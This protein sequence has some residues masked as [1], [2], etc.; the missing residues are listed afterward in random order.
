MLCELWLHSPPFFQWRG[1]EGEANWPF[2]GGTE[3]TQL[4]IDFSGQVVLVTG[5]SRGIGA[6]TANEFARHGAQVVVNYRADREGAESVAAEIT[7]SGGR[8]VLMQADVG[9]EPDIRRMMQH[10]AAELGPLRVVV[11]N[12]TGT[13]RDHFLDVTLDQLDVMWATNVR[14]PFLISQLAARQMI[15]AGKGGSILHVS[16]IL[17]QLTIENR[18]I[19]AMTKSALEGLTRSMAL[20]LADYG[21]RVNTVAPGLIDT[22]ALR[23]GIANVGE[24]IKTFIPGGEFGTVAEVARVIVFLASD[25]A[26]YINGALIP[27]DRGLGI[28]E[29]G[30]K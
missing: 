3:R 13:N 12:A 30:P 25:A 20:D 8:A 7:Q 6:A 22:Q 11:H 9:S 2:A 27:V 21:I 10:I 14:G 24:V 23:D 18:S 29:A 4:E 15:A 26:S 16:S 28:R 19:Y 1:V 5:A 17:A